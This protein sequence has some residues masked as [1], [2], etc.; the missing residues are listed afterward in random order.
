RKTSETEYKSQ[1]YRTR[2]GATLKYSKF[3]SQ[4]N[5]ICYDGEE[6]CH[7]VLQNAQAQLA[8]SHNALV[9]EEVGF[10]HIETF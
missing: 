5:K 9:V 6:D 4:N 10:L 7:H 2:S 3:N 8:E 1:V